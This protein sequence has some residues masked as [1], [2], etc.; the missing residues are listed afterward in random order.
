M[1]VP[2]AQIIGTYGER[3][4]SGSNLNGAYGN[5]NAW[6]ADGA[7]DHTATAHDPQH[8]PTDPLSADEAAMIAQSTDLT[9]SCSGVCYWCPGNGKAEITTIL[10]ATGWPDYILV[11]PYGGMWPLTGTYGDPYVL[12]NATARGVKVITILDNY[13]DGALGVGTDLATRA[14]YIEITKRYEE[15]ATFLGATA[16]L[17]SEKRAL[18]QEV[19][20]FKATAAAA[21]TRGVRAMGVFAPY[22]SVAGGVTNGFLY[23]AIT[24]QVSFMLEELG[25]QILHNNS[26]YAPLDAATLGKHYPIDFWLYDVRVTLDFISD[27][28]STAWPHPALVA[29]QYARY[30]NGGHIHSYEHGTEILKHVGE[31]LGKAQR[32]EP[33]TTCTEVADVTDVHYRT[34]GLGRGQYACPK[35]VEYD[36][37]V[38]YASVDS[39]YLARPGVAVAAGAAVAALL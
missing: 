34:V 25:M 9:P 37:C 22:V 19:N 27:T 15:L 24:D 39:A 1:G 5:G 8:W 6:D 29:D 14:G 20:N 21:A 36:W 33:A 16:N 3:C 12:G 30:P 7:L 18:C 10:D 2:H 26:G 28:F 13:N 11:G 38:N 17:D 4:T 32:I 23:G 31:A 35:P